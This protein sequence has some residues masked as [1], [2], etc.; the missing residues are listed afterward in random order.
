MENSA[1]IGYYVHSAVSNTEEWL[2]DYDA[3]ALQAAEDAGFILVAVREDGSREVVKAADVKEPTPTMNGVSVPTTSYVDTRAEA[4]VAVFD[5]L[6]AIVD[7]ESAAATADET[8]ENAE[9]VDLV[10]AYKDA[11]IRLKAL[12]PSVVTE[13]E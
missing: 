1:I 11:V 10:Q 3:T 13:T 12:T 2:T 4:T 5:A 8:D 6:T 9:A 7:P